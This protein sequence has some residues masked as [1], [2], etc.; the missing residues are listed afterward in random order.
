[1]MGMFR[2]T[3]LPTK[4]LMGSN[5]LVSV[6]RLGRY[7]VSDF[8]L[9]TTDFF[10]SVDD[11]PRRWSGK[12]KVFRRLFTLDEPIYMYAGEGSDI[13]GMRTDISNEDDNDE[14]DVRS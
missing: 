11:S 9:T 14:V 3:S 6:G 8:S 5:M 4:T 12:I 7:L 1:M 10:L 2:I 13:C